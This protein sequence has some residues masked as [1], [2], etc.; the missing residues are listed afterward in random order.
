MGSDCSKGQDSETAAHL[1]PDE[2]G[3]CGWP[4]GDH[5]LQPT[6]HSAALRPGSCCLRE[7]LGQGK[8][9]SLQDLPKIEVQELGLNFSE[10]QDLCPSPQL[11]GSFGRGKRACLGEPVLCTPRMGRQPGGASPRTGRLKGTTQGPPP[12]PLWIPQRAEPMRTAT[13]RSASL[14]IIGLKVSQKE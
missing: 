2:W 12:H 6:L 7:S 13:W 11:L 9:Q 10:W 5:G 14:W 3:A 1:W 8:A 4:W